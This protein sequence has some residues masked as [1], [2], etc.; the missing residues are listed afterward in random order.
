MMVTEGA[1]RECGQGGESR[2]KAKGAG[3]D[4][5]GMV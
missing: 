1:R 3:V 4:H 2:P 5:V